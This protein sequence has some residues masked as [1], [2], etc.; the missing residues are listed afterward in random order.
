MLRARMKVEVLPENVSLDKEW[1]MKVNTGT[2]T[3]DVC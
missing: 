1:V 2:D 3:V